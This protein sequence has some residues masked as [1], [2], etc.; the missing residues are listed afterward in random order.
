MCCFLEPLGISG[1]FS[2]ALYTSTLQYSITLQRTVLHLFSAWRHT[3]AKIQEPVVTPK[4]V[5]GL[6]VGL[7]RT[8]ICM[9]NASHT[10]T[11]R[12]A[13]SVQV[14]H[15]Y[16][17]GLNASHTYI[18]VVIQVMYIH[19]VGLNASHTYMCRRV[20]C[21]SPI[22]ICNTSHTHI[23]HRAQCKSYLYIL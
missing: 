11:C 16:V 23:C 8:Y 4:E 14:I 22:Y 5:V 3:V 21:N 12:R 19:V 6:F 18:Y 7:F 20:Q 13:L 10:Y 15:I 9:T 17:V 2:R 1:S